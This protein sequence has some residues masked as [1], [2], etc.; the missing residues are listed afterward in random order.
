MHHLS[1]LVKSLN[2]WNVPIKLEGTKTS[3]H[4]VKSQKILQLEMT[5]AAPIMLNM[6]PLYFS[7]TCNSHSSVFLSLEISLTPQMRSCLNITCTQYIC[8]GNHFC[9]YATWVMEKKRETARFAFSLGVGRQ[10][11]K[12][13]IQRSPTKS[14]GRKLNHLHNHWEIVTSELMLLPQTLLS[15]MLSKTKISSKMAAGNLA[16]FIHPSAKQEENPT[17]TGSYGTKVKPDL[18][19]DQPI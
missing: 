14:Y 11:R 2:S 3:S 17:H 19:T 8:L 7:R 13:G 15:S 18:Y 9:Y 6:Y 10:N 5:A 12:V 1:L 16:S 4:S